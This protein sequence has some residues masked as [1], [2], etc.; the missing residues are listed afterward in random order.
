ML[1]VVTALIGIPPAALAQENQLVTTL[2]IQTPEYELAPDRITVAD[3]AM[4]D[5]SGAPRLPIKGFTVNLPPTGTWTMTFESANN[6]ILPDLVNIP[7]TEVPDL[8]LNT[9]SN[10]TSDP[11]NLPSAVPVL[12]RPDASIYG[13]NAFYPP[14]PVIAGEPQIQGGQRVLPIRVF[15]F[16]YNPV[17]RQ[18]RFHPD[19]R[20]TVSTS[21]AES[22]DA[23]SVVLENFGGQAVPQT[24]GTALRIHTQERGFYRL[25]YDDLVNRGVSVGPGGSNP[26]NFAMFYKG[27]PIDIRLTGAEDN[28]FDPGDLV[29]F[30]AEPY[31]L[32]R[33]QDY[34]VY[35]FLEDGTGYAFPITTRPVTANFAPTVAST[36]SQTLRV[37]RNLDYRSLYVRPMRDD[38]FFDSQLYANSSTSV[39]TR[40]YT[41]HLD[42]PVTSGSMQ[43]SALIHGGDVNTSFNPD[44]SLQI[45]LNGQAVG[46]YQWDGSVDHAIST[47][48]PAA[49]LQP[50]TTVDLVAALNQLPGISFYWISPDWVELTYPAM[51][52]AE[53]NRMYVEGVISGSGNIVTT[54]F[55]TGGVSVYDVRDPRSPVLLDG[56][57][58]QSNGS[59]YLV[60]WTETETQPAY[61]LTTKTALL[62]PTAIEVDQPSNWRSP[63]H[64]YDYIAIVGTERSAAGTTV[65]GSELSAAIQPLLDYRSTEGMLV[66]K[67]DLQDIYDEYSDGFVDPDAIR[68]FLAYAYFNWQRQP[69]YVLLVGDGSFVF[70]NEIVTALHNL[71]PPYLPHVDP[72]IGDIPADSRYVSVDG[73]EDY[74]PEMAIGRIPANSAADVIAVVN[75]T[76][77]YEDVVATPNGAWNQRAVY[78]ADDYADPAGNF[79]VLSDNVR[80]NWL[81]SAY[82]SKPTYY[83]MDTSLDTGAEMRTAI[84]D[85][86][87]QGALFLQWFGHGS[88]VRWG[89]VSMFNIFDVPA[90]DPNS[91]TPFTMHNA[92]WTGYFTYLGTY[93]QALGEVLVTTPGRG[94]VADYSPSGLHIGTALLT[95]DQGVHKA[96]FQDRLPRAGDVVNAS[97]QFYFENSIA[98][99]DVID[100]MIYFGDPA[101]K[102]R[103]PEGDLST[104]TFEVSDA[105]AGA[106][107]TL[108]YTVTIKN[109]SVFTVTHPQVEADYPQDWVTVTDPNGAMDNGDMLAWSRPDLLPGSQDI[110]T[111]TLKTNLGLPPGTLDLIVPAVISSQMAP[112]TTLQVSTATIYAEPDMS[113]SILQ[114]HRPW[115]G[116]GYPV[117]LTAT[118]VNTGTAVSVGT[119]LTLSLG[120]ELGTPVSST[121]GAVYDPFNHQLLWTG[122]VGVTQP[123]QVAFTSVVSPTISACNQQVVVVGSVVDTLN[124]TTPVSA[125]VNIAVP[126]V[127]CSG[128]VDIVDIQIVAGRWGTTLGQPEYLYEHDLNGNDEIDVNDIIIAANHWN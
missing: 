7:S 126:D 121:N 59:S 23:S 13:V 103:L 91:R 86:F 67:V 82:I 58:A 84:K 39:V 41:F 89:S 112:T 64:N 114:T 32:G 40:T 65:L 53:N 99:H 51:A 6:Q 38:H 43:L 71:V 85:E 10:W 72:W 92:C 113:G 44:Q 68:D 110:V 119:Q 116:A 98:Y 46:L 20:V 2:R 21:G 12:D 96:M 19:I 8:N 79:H 15:P 34:N 115:M 75:K 87:N 29:A 27:E 78:V 83:R 33:Y 120:S 54:G 60:Y 124:V 37:E 55:T 61:F 62:A 4:N 63:E 35:Y 18:V 16:Q 36:I 52:D 101:L 76:L 73:A 102:L 48:L 80:L 3:A 93:G 123:E 25:T 128:N 22:P 70:R 45:R 94:S 74:L 47:V 31:D 97:K 104:S 117:T 11:D 127:N 57:G 14:S 1:A 95:L 5:V 9:P 28:T 42:D 17:T 108:Q 66:A 109:T 56:T 81:P 125:T 105:I 90:L 111:F 77:A 107:T 118:M 88:T 49:S 26:N 106:D 50:N 122:D 24:G 69:Q 100:S 30:Y